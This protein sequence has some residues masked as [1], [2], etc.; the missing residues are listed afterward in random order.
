MFFSIALVTEHSQVCSWNS[1]RGTDQ[2][3]MCHQV[4]SDRSQVCT[5]TKCLPGF[6]GPKPTQERGVW[7]GGE[8]QGLR[9]GAWASLGHPGSC[10]GTH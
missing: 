4:Q 10:L 7:D 3:F 8:G 6:T 5:G 9:L 1:T 2:K